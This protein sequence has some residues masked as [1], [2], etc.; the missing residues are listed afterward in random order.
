MPAHG[1]GYVCVY[2]REGVCVYICTCAC[3][4]EDMLRAVNGDVLRAVRNVKKFLLYTP[5]HSIFL[6]N[7]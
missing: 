6:W 3:S 2:M 5:P 4:Q 7:C 1:A